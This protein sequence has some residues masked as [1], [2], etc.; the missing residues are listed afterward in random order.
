MLRLADRI[1]AV[2]GTAM[3]CA[4]AA[5]AIAQ[6]HGSP[7]TYS[8]RDEQA[9]WINDPAFHQFY[10]VTVDAFAN[11]PD[12][13]DRA[14]YEAKSREIFT[15]F[16]TSHNMPVEAMLDHLKA[17]PGEMID[18]ATREPE[19]LASYDA[20]VE[21]LMGPQAFPADAERIGGD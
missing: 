9:A 14:A 7:Q 12:R 16:A 13:V 8:A 17:I 18:N 3:M 20:F 4:A 5:P 11:G 2:L 21:A 15:A 19:I 6:E 1:Y 10:Q